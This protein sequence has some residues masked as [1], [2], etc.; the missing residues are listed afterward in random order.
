MS[1]LGAVLA[2]MTFVAGVL[3]VL[4]WAAAP[5]AAPVVPSS[6]ALWTKVVDNVGAVPPR[7]WATVSGGLLGGVALWAWTGWPVMLGAVPLAVVGLP[8]LLGRPR[9]VEIE[10]LQA[11]DRWVRGMTATIAAGKSITDALRASARQATPSADCST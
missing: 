1:L 3:A 7:T 5:S 2:G 11:L 10:L 6:T 4:L 9:Q 8:R